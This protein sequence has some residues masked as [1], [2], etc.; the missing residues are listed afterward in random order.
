MKV[1]QGRE[2]E[3]QVPRWI[4]NWIVEQSAQLHHKFD[5]TRGSNY[6]QVGSMELDVA[7][8]PEEHAQGK[9]HV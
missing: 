7:E 2:G 3:M 1:G 8:I 4:D 6:A 9:D 5:N